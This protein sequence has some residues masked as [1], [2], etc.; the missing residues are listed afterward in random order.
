MSS[1][2]WDDYEVP[3]SPYFVFVEGD[4]GRIIGQGTAPD[5][6]QV[7]RLMSEAGDDAA[8][9]AS[10]A[11]SDARARRAERRHLDDRAREARADEMLMAAGILSRRPEPVPGRRVTDHRPARISGQAPPA[12]SRLHASRGL[13][14]AHQRPARRCARGVQHG[15]RPRGLHRGA[16][17]RWCTSPTS[18]SPRNA[19]TS[20]AARSSSWAHATS[21]SCCSSTSRRTRA[22]RCSRPRAFLASSPP[23]DFDPTML[24]RGHLRP[25]RL[26]D[27]L[28]RGRPRL[29]PLRRARQRVRPQ[30]RS[31]SS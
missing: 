17:A 14:R 13:G 18:P 12:R 20:A 30:L 4:S 11:A 6:D 25:G 16:P 29:L 23:A 15:R 31:S 27:V 2:S 10:R 24:R 22:N 9:N 3:G 1:D 28:P 26:P 19:A 5:W 21:S 8:L 7:V